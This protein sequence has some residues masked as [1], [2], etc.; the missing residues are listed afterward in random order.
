M[1]AQQTSIYTCILFCTIMYNDYTMFKEDHPDDKPNFALPL[2]VFIFIVAFIALIAAGG[3]NTKSEDACKNLFTSNICPHCK[4]TTNKFFNFKSCINDRH[5]NNE[6]ISFIRCTICKHADNNE[7]VDKSTNSEDYDEDSLYDKKGIKLI[8]FVL[9]IIMW[10]T[11]VIN[12]TGFIICIAAFIA[13]GIVF[14]IEN[15]VIDA[16][17]TARYKKHVINEL[18]SKAKAKIDKEKAESEAYANTEEHIGPD[19]INVP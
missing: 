6:L 14:I 8:V 9:I 17:R 12:L 16:R 18:K 7:Q 4:Y 19:C 15:C 13:V 11:K 10:I 5:V 3:I 2:Y 1:Q